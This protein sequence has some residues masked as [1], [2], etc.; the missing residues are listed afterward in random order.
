MKPLFRRDWEPDGPPHAVVALVHGLG[1][2]SGRYERMAA[3]FT[4]RGIAVSAIDLR[5][6]GQSPG[7]RGDTRFAPAIADIEALVG[8]CGARGAPVSPDFRAFRA[9]FD[10]RSASPTTSSGE[11]NGR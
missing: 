1:E 3:R 4:D 7:A 5:G 6:H 10:T 11:P 8:E 2:H 9:F